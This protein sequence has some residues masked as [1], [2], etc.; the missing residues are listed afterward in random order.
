MKEIEE[1]KEMID[2]SKFLK[3][4]TEDTF[5]K[6]KKSYKAFY[7]DNYTYE[8]M[9]HDVEKA[10][11][12]VNNFIYN[13]DPAIQRFLFAK[14]D[15]NYREVVELSPVDEYLYWFLAREI[16]R[17]ISHLRVEHTFGRYSADNS[18]KEDEDAENK[19]F[20]DSSELDM[21][22]LDDGYNFDV[23]WKREWRIYR[24]FIYE[25]CEGPKYSEIL[26]F[27][28][29]NYYDTISISRLESELYKAVMSHDREAIR[30]EKIGYIKVLIDFFK[31]WNL[32]NWKYIPLQV[33]IPQSSFGEASRIMAHI[34][35]LEFD[36]F[37][38][39]LCKNN[40]ALFTRYADDISILI[41]NDTDKEL[42][43]FELN[44]KIRQIGLNFNTKSKMMKKD[45]FLEYE[46]YSDLNSILECN[47]VERFDEIAKSVFHINGK[48][49][50]A[51]I[52]TFVKFVLK[53]KKILNMDGIVD[54][55][56]FKKM[57]KYFI[58]ENCILKYNAEDILGTLQSFATINRLNKVLKHTLSLVKTK[59]TNAFDYSLRI[60]LTSLRNHDLPYETKKS[61]NFINKLL[62]EIEG[63]IK[64][65]A[66]DPLTGNWE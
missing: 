15:F 27:D 10:C 57:I 37:A 52:L 21:A 65:K 56:Y 49:E 53:S 28:V 61:I 60:A 9:K 48:L 8:M 4:F 31:R 13:P 41:S 51:R 22:D 58:K 12:K 35:L 24:K 1:I 63:K 30:E 36:N 5:N 59:K 34:Y 45:K 64:L 2:K 6:L 43:I 66:Y 44:K 19:N 46:L 47:S 32:K 3:L 39:D 55:Y 33:G 16:I 18:I 17:G 11:D 26:F 14:S 38:L 29:S 50:N 42:I 23:D 40:N 62:C 54:S 7:M 20:I 25:K